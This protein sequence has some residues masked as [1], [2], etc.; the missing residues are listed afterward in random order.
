MLNFKINSSYIIF[1]LAVLFSAASVF[2]YVYSIY[3]TIDLSYKIEKELR[4]LKSE[5]ALYQQAE[6]KYITKLESLL[7]EG[8]TILGLVSPQDK[9]FVDRFNAVAR[10]EL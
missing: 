2:I 3:S 4:S 9:I 5:N 8:K 1:W 6:E 10:A 7:E